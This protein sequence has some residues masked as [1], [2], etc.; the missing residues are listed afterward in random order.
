MHVSFDLIKDLIEDS[1]DKFSDYSNTDKPY[2]EIRPLIDAIALYLGKNIAVKIVDENNIE[3]STYKIPELIELND[4]NST[5][6]LVDTISIYISIKISDK[7][8]SSRLLYEKPLSS[9]DSK[10]NEIFDW[11]K[12]DHPNELKVALFYKSNGTQNVDFFEYSIENYEE[13]K[14][15]Q[16]IKDA[17]REIISDSIKIFEK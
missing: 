12:K 15:N 4:S 16:K 13:K 17:I 6:I 7:N 5:L 2:I 10:L 3:C 14:E 1:I 11:L 8:T 9:D